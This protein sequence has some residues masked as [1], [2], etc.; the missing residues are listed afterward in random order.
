MAVSVA[1]KMWVT[2]VCIVIGRQ[3]F[4][5]YQTLINSNKLTDLS[6]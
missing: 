1:A 4:A 5:D 6:R 2:V 3:Q